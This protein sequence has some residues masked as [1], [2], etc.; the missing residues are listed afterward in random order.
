MG[1]DE[2]FFEEFELDDYE[3]EPPD[4]LEE[5]LMNCAIMPDGTCSLAGSEECDWDCPFSR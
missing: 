2:E 4:A 3:E 5:A 1:A